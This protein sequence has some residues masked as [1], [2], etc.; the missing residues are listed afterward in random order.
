LSHRSEHQ[1]IQ[2]QNGQAQREQR[3][4]QDLLD[5]PNSKQRFKGISKDIKELEK[6]PSCSFYDIVLQTFK[7]IKTVP[8]KIHWRIYLEL[9]DL[10]KRESKFSFAAS[11]FKIVVSI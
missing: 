5:S 9:A 11:M 2:S 8:Q 4:C 1:A 7:M 6:S 10:A 3:M